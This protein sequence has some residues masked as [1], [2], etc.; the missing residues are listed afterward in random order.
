MEVEDDEKE[1]SDM[2]EGDGVHAARHEHDEEDFTSE[3]DVVVTAVFEVAGATEIARIDV[4][5]RGPDEGVTTD[6][7]ETWGEEVPYDG[8]GTKSSK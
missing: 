8:G 2:T 5:N 7:S 6:I 4:D 3:V 1:H